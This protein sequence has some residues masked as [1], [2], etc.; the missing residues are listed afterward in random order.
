MLDFG[1][2]L[3]KK[4]ASYTFPKAENLKLKQDRPQK[5]PVL[6]K[7]DESDKTRLTETN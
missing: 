1:Y 4:Q 7:A 6:A 3:Y 5:E 2:A